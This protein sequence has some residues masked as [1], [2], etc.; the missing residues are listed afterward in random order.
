MMILGSD[1]TQ[2]RSAGRE[3]EGRAQGQ[4]CTR[5]TCGPEGDAQTLSIGVPLVKGAQTRH[6][7]YHSHYFIGSKTGILFLF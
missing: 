2:E 1:L 4:G 5:E 6:Q 7:A 3:M